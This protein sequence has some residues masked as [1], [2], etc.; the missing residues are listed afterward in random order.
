MGIQQSY[1]SVRRKQEVR[2][3][4]LAAAAD[5]FMSEYGMTLREF[6]HDYAP[7]QIEYLQKK[8]NQRHDI[9][10]MKL[11][12]IQHS[13]PKTAKESLKRLKNQTRDYIM[14]EATVDTSISNA[15]IERFGIKVIERP[16]G[17]DTR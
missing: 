13:S 4:N 1:E 11:I 3:N 5:L 6:F 17:T 2:L 15:Q 12:S 8:I 7:Y 9:E 10:Y 14:S 16:D